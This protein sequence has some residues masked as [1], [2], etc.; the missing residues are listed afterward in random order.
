M[1]LGR[2]LLAAVSVAM[3]TLTPSST[4]A[5]SSAETLAYTDPLPAEPKAIVEAFFDDYVVW[6]AFAH[7]RYA[8][9]KDFAEAEAAYRRL[10]DLYC[11]PQKEHQGIA[12]GTV[13]AFSPQ[14]LEFMEQRTDDRGLLLK[15]RSTNAH[16]GDHKDIHEFLLVKRE[17]RWRLEEVLYYE[18]FGDQWLASL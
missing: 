5:E 8:K 13:P 9:T 11:G 3:A 15:V 12:F 1:R 14:D 2:A 17:A 18:E 6:N 4:A 16:P 10:I 7:E